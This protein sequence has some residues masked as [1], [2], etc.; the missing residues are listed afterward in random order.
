MVALQTSGDEKQ[1]WIDLINESNGVSDCLSFLGQPRVVEWTEGEAQSCH[2]E[3]K[4]KLHHFLLLSH[5]QVRQNLV[6]TGLGVQHLAWHDT[7]CHTELCLHSQQQL[8]QQHLLQRFPS[9]GDLFLA[10]QPA[11][12]QRR[13]ACTISKISAGWIYSWLEDTGEVSVQLIWFSPSCR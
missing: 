4:G 1:L 3:A 10:P 13:K 7:V 5:W 8:R 6:Q 9:E 12:S 11:C 2:S